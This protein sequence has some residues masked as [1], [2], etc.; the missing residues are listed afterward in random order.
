MAAVSTGVS[1]AVSSAFNDRV[2][3]ATESS[4][5]LAMLLLATLLGNGRDGNN[6]SFVSLAIWRDT[7]WLELLAQSKKVVASI[8]GLGSFCAELAC[9]LLVCVQKYAFEVNWELEIDHR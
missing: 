8:S 7:A 1:T 2:N 5:K 9:S 3:K 4:V 6:V